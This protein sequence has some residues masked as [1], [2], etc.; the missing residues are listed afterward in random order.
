MQ[1]FIYEDETSVE[2]VPVG[3]LVRYKLKVEMKEGAVQ[4]GLR[5][6]QSSSQINEC[7]LS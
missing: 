1:N 6:C 2:E 4:L 3:G 5:I 7:M